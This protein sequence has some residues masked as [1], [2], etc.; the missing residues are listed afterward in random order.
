MLKYHYVLNVYQIYTPRLAFGRKNGHSG[1][2]KGHL[3]A[4][5]WPIINRDDGF[6]SITQFCWGCRSADSCPVRLN[7]YLLIGVLLELSNWDGYICG[8]SFL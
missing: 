7:E 1:C 4:F 8:H 2:P 5:E 3:F 6:Q